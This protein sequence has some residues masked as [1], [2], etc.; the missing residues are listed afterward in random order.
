LRLMRPH[1]N[2]C[3]QHSLNKAIEDLRLQIADLG[4]IKLVFL[5][6]LPF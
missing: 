6:A 3:A 1:L 4:L 2:A 5:F